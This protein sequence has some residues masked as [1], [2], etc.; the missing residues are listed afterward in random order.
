MQ[1][2]FRYVLDLLPGM[3][4][5][6]IVHEDVQ[7]AE[8]FANVGDRF[9]AEFAILNLAWKEEAAPSLRFDKLPCLLRNALLLQ[10]NHRHVRAFPRKSDRHSAADP[11]IAA[12][13][14]RNTV[15]E[16]TTAPDPCVGG[17]GRGPHLVLTSRLAPLMLR[18]SC[19]FVVRVSL[20]F[21]FVS[22]DGLRK[23]L[24]HA[25]HKLCRRAAA[26]VGTGPFLHAQPCSS[27]RAGA[28]RRAISLHHTALSGAKA[29]GTKKIAGKFPTGIRVQ[30]PLVS[31]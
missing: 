9:L 8:L 22:H 17:D 1:L 10:I 3:L 14:E 28:A 25:L 27:E 18:G 7:T 6:G 12:G 19:G 21:R 29:R 11:A 23:Y 31:S 15:L 13:D 20:R 5:G 30:N 16:R 24:S 2:F 4:L 26:G